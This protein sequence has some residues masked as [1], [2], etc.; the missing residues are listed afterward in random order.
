MTTQDVADKLTRGEIGELMET[1]PQA[2]ARMGISPI[3]LYRRLARWVERGGKLPDNC[4]VGRQYWLSSR[5]WDDMAQLRRVKR[6][7]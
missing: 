5:Q 3:A 7:T 6:E 1:L 4:R 2:A